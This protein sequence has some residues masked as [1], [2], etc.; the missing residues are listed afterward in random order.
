MDKDTKSFPSFYA[1][2]NYLMK[3]SNSALSEDK[4]FLQQ[5]KHYRKTF[6]WKE[7]GVDNVWRKRLERR[8]KKYGI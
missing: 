3:S 8:L 2:L 7:L 6:S 4:D 5:L 1:N